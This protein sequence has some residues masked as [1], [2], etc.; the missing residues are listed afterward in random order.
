MLLREHHVCLNVGEEAPDFALPDQNGQDVRL[1]DFL[2][3]KNVLLTLH[4]GNLSSGCKDHFRFYQE[5][6]PEFEDVDTQVLGVN[7]ASVQ[8]NRAWLDEV[9]ELGFPVLADFAPLGDATLKYDCYVPKEG[10]GKRAV[11]LV[12]K[13]GKLRHI[14][15]LKA[16]GD[17]C[18]DMQ[19]IFG[20]IRELN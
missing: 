12:D 10:Y 3:K 2:G 6:L 16:T 4:P 11:F 8:S 14:E 7:M 5:Y 13:E 9:G 1:S 18:P 17:V 15:V 19:K 20:L